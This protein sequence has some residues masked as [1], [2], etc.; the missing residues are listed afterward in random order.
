MLKL[1]YLDTIKVSKNSFH[2][3]ILNIFLFFALLTP[4]DVFGIKLIALIILILSNIKVIY[5]FLF[6]RENFYFLFFLVLFPFF[7][8]L[9]SYVKTLYFVETIRY[10]YIFS[11]LLLIPICDYRKIDYKKSFMNILTVLALV[12]TISAFLDLA[13]IIPINNNLLLNFLNNN[14]EAQISVSPYAI[15]H[16]VLFLNASPLLIVSFCYF[17][18]KGNYNI[19]VVHF[20]ALLFSGTRANIYLALFTLAVYLFFNQKLNVLKP[21]LLIILTI[22]IIKYGNELLFRFRTI[23]WAK[24]TGDDIRNRTFQSICMVLKENPISIFLG[25][26][27]RSYYYNYGR[28]EWVNESELTYLELLRQVGVVGFIPLMIF[29]IRP[30]CK[31]FMK[32]QFFAVCLGY[33]LYLVKCMFDP[34]LFNSTGFILVTLMYWEFFLDSKENVIDI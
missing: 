31:L 20:F 7:L 19:A 27:A 6:K 28:L 15:F 3:F 12:I 23:N 30:L 22:L 24:T 4:A 9:I 5:N 11:Y 8:V 25:M 18:F 21:F 10:F 29:F 17:I 16:Y 32:P 13:K 1:S 33:C 14:G 34:F 2:R 26:G